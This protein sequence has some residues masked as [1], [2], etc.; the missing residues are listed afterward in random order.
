MPSPASRVTWPS[1][2]AFRGLPVGNHLAGQMTVTLLDRTEASLPVVGATLVLI[3]G[4]GLTTEVSQFVRVTTVAATTRE[5]EKTTKALYPA[6][7]HSR[8]Q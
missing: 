3:K 8:R 5:F 2:L 6:G 1:V 7:N 4:E